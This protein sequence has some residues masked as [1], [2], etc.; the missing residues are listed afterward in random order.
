MADKVN[1]RKQNNKESAV[2]LD[3]D[4]IS[5]EL[6]QRKSSRHFMS[7]VERFTRGMVFE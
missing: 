4:P 1:K 7:M 3:G 2:F 5:P 6:F